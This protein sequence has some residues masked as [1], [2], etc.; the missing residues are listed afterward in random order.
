MKRPGRDINI[1]NLSML[2]VMTGAFGAVM[3]VI[4][5]LLTQK[6]GVESMGCP[7]LKEE[8]VETSNQL[9]MA[10]E[11]L[12]EIKR[13]RDYRADPEE[14][15]AIARIR[16]SLM[17][18]FTARDEEDS[19]IKLMI[20]EKIVMAVDLSGSMS[21]KNNKYNE[22]RI[23]QLRAALKMFVSSM[24]ENY[25]LDIVYFPAFRENINQKQCPDFEIKP[26]LDPACR[27]FEFRDEAYD[28]PELSC[29]KYGYFAGKLVNLSTE[30]EK[31]FFYNRIDCLEPYHDTPT[32]EMM[33]FILNHPAYKDAEGIILYSDGEPDSIRRK[34]DTVD[35]L[36]AAINKL[37][38][39]NKRIF[40][41]GV[42]KEF[43]LGKE[44]E[45]V[46]FLRK[47]AEQNRGFFTGF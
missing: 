19:L 8:L 47:L 26:E 27:K 9:V 20:P 34:H 5:V 44:S 10:R 30:K 16:D 41:V 13:K 6:I 21:P 46:D 25:W 2:D 23:S 18:R 43:A 36:L 45:A 7:E 17:K 14:R 12:E 24:D 32:R 33:E 37:N 28:S 22:D 4:I 35:E 39:G 11:E 31:Q 40:T 15:S 3:I 29:Y 1:F 38:S 42:G